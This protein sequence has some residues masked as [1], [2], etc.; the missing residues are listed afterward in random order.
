[1]PQKQGQSTR[2]V[3]K[4]PAETAKSG[5]NVNTG[6][7]KPTGKAVKIPQLADYLEL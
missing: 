7:S 3:S 1:M 6:A 5:W 4:G 2:K